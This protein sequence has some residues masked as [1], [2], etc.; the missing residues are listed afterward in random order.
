MTDIRTLDD[1]MALAKC[2]AAARDATN[3]VRSDLARRVR[4]ALHSRHRALRSRIAEEEV[5]R[6][7]LE[8]AI[9]AAPE[10]FE[11]PRTRAVDGIKFGMRKQTGAIDF[12]DE[13]KVIERIRKKFPDRVDVLVRTTVAVDKTALRKLPARELAMLG[14][15][16]ADA[17]DE[18]TIKA[19]VTDADRLAEAIRAFL[20][21]A[22]DDGEL[23]DA[24]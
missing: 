10:L 12:G 22:D 23:E 5:A 11:K 1:I 18:V 21:D 8:A 20:P 6:E 9:E 7:E 15:S 4:K 17:V 24:A 3:E 2:Y 16:I 19:A 14:V 13:A